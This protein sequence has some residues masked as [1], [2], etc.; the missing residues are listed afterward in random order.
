M[1]ICGNHLMQVISASLRT[2]GRTTQVCG[3]Q[4]ERVARRRER[5]PAPS[6][7]KDRRRPK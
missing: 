5:M 4:I 7:G 6:Y 3:T 2:G 1:V